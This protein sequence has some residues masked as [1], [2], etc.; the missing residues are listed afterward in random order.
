MFGPVEELSII[1]ILFLEVDFV[2]DS[3]ILVVFELALVLGAIWFQVDS[4]SICLVVFELSSICV[5]VGM[6]KNAISM[7]LKI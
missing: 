7:H 6:Q 3:V 5:S 4:L 1:N 2:S